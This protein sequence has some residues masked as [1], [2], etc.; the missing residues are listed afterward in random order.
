MP[1]PSDFSLT[2]QAVDEALAK[3]ARPKEHDVEGQREFVEE[4]LDMLEDR[5]LSFKQ[6]LLIKEKRVRLAKLLVEITA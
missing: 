3:I 5:E 1:T 2:M 4:M 6:R